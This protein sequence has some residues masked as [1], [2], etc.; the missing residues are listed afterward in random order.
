M[1]VVERASV[2][3]FPIHPGPPPRVLLLRRTPERGGFWQPVTGGVE[4]AGGADGA[5]SGEAA[6]RR[7]LAE[8]TGLSAEVLLDL[9]LE[10]AF[11]GYDGVRY[12]ERAFAAIVQSDSF[13]RSEE[14]DDA[15]FVPLDEAAALLRW[16]ENREGLRRAVAVLAAAGFLESGALK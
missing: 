3:V 13:E 2:A 12:R 1:N 15:R 4:P 6:A 10:T 8:E 16:D 5:E 14:H 11:L 7:E 9:G